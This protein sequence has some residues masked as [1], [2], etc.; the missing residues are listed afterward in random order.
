MGN[1]RKNQGGRSTGGEIGSQPAKGAYDKAVG[2][3]ELIGQEYDSTAEGEGKP[4]QG[5]GQP[6]AKQGGKQ[7]QGGGVQKGGAPSEDTA[8]KGDIKGSDWDSAV[9]E[10]DDLQDAQ[11]SL[12]G[13]MGHKQTPKS[14]L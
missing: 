4:E 5:A 1:A 13:G 8:G 7:P 11:D 9:E 14:E 12:I 3:D 6:G 10:A 2:N